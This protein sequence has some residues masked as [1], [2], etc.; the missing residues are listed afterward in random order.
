M[1]QVARFN[2]SVS[3]KGGAVLSD[4]PIELTVDIGVLFCVGSSKLCKDSLSRLVSSVC[5][6]N[7]SSPGLAS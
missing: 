7:C 1:S 6:Q 4:V 2:D 3:G 5:P